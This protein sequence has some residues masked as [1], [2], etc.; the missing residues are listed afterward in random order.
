MFKNFLKK[1]VNFFMLTLSLMI[2]ASC[3]SAG[4]NSV[5]ET[6]AKD[7]DISTYIKKDYVV[8]DAS[9]T[10]RPGWIIDA[11]EWATSN[12]D[13]TKEYRFFSFE[14]SPK[15][16][17]EIACNLAKANAKAD[18]AGEVATFIKSTL[19][20]SEEGQAAIDPN[21]PLTLPLRSFVETNLTSKIQEVIVGA[22]IM[23]TH[24]EKR[25]Y[26][27]DLGAPRDFVGFTC[28]TL[29][30]VK[31]EY[32]ES[33]I[34]LAR[35]EMLNRTQDKSMKDKVS[36]ALATAEKDFEVMRGI[37]NQASESNQK[38]ESNQATEEIKKE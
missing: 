4:K 13:D 5:K 37:R 1:C 24:W 10:S 25:S 3:S 16:G 30:K 28:G 19:G 9:S 21:N 15:V 18:I 11:V 14:T 32:I 22:Q 6:V 36:M 29:V 8:T 26:K 20:S 23:K 17:R 12:N 2:L 34:D 27:K 33:A 38:V 31:N 35:S 7:Q